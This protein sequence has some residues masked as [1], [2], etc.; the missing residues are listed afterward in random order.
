M[1]NVSLSRVNP[2]TKKPTSPQQCIKENL[3]T[4]SPSKECVNFTAAHV[5]ANYAPFISFK[6]I[7]KNAV[8][9]IEFQVKGTS[10]EDFRKAATSLQ[11]RNAKRNERG[12][13]EKIEL[14]LAPDNSKKSIAVFHDYRGKSNQIGFI[15]EKIASKILPLIDKGHHFSASVVDVFGGEKDKFSN[16][17]VRLRLEYLSSPERSPN[18]RKIATVRKAFRSLVRQKSAFNLREEEVIKSKRYRKATKLKIDN[19]RGEFR[20]YQ[21]GWE[22]LNGKLDKPS[23]V[24]NSRNHKQDET[25]VHY[26]EKAVDK[27][28]TKSKDN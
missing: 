20:V 5:M 26:V 1:V 13:T 24:K 28:A 11:W 19:E 7:H 9:G 23:T 4:H 22:Q 8:L 27:M 6:G 16:V 10:Q 18:E 14:R 25:F 2:L 12:E 21:K 17:G 3:L 15:P